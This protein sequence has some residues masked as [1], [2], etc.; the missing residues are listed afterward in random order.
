MSRF[1][2]AVA[3]EAAQLLVTRRLA[4][5]PGAVLPEHLRPQTVEEALQIQQAFANLWCEQTDDSIGGWKCLQP[6]E[7][8][9]II[10]PI[11][12]STINSVAPVTA[13]TT[14][15]KV[16]IEPELAFYIAKDLPARETPY[17]ASDVDAAIGRTHLALELIH[18]RYA[19]PGTTTF[20]DNLADNLV[21]QGL[22]V[23]PE[24]D[25]TQAAKASTVNF[26]A[27]A[28]GQSIFAGEGRHPN[29][30][31]RLPLYWLAEFL[32][33]RGEG[34]QAGQVIITGS[35]AGIWDIP[36]GSTLTV[37]YQGLGTLTVS[38]N[39]A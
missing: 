9:L 36:T 16:R 35:Y 29:L 28:N 39:A 23:G 18:C 26:A 37:E 7:D 13:V 8:K 6:N 31:P 1:S 10:A 14:A 27:N 15:E 4:A 2:A 32:R 20:A 22:F 19:E 11:F 3:E 30:G 12:T 17:T 34:L 25:A 21:N 33:S 38:F 24:V 5:T